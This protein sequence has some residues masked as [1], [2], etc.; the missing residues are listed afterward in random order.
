MGVSFQVLEHGTKVNNEDVSLKVFC[1]QQ[2]LNLVGMKL[3][4]IEQLGDIR[5]EAFR[6]NQ[7]H[8]G[9]V[10]GDAMRS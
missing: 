4:S 10:E 2:E 1:M 8:A 5:L 3:V 7:A 6:K 9:S